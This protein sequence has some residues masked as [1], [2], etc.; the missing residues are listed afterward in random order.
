M[1]EQQKRK[2][3]ISSIAIH[4]FDKDLIEKKNN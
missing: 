1:Q 4:L 2:H 3:K